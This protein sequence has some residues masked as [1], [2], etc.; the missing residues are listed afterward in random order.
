MTFYVLV[1][2]TKNTSVNSHFDYLQ[3]DLF[4]SVS[5]GKKRKKVAH[6]VKLRLIIYWFNA[7]GLRVGIDIERKCVFEKEFGRGFFQMGN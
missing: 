3:M 5:N 7:H 4:M 1:F 2:N 6:V